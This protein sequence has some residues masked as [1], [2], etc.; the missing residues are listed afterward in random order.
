MKSMTGFGYHE[1]QD[2]KRHITITLKSY[3][4]RFLDI[5]VFLPPAL[6]QL[7]QRFREYLA[8]RIRRG[9]VELY[10]KCEEYESNPTVILDKA[11]VRAYAQALRE[12]AVEIGSNEPIRLSH[13]LKLEG[14]L[15]AEQSRD[16][17][18]YWGALYPHLETA[19]QDFERMRL[20]EGETTEQDIRRL[21][22]QIE[23]SLAVVESCASRIEEK[24]REDLRARFQEL[25][26]GGL[27][28]ARLMAETAVLLMRFDIHE[29]LMRIGNHLESFQAVMAEGGADGKKL[30]FLCQEL[31]REVNTVG[32]KSLFAE[33]NQ[34]VV[35]LKD[36]LEKIR[37]Q[38]RNVE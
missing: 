7:E 24:V 35:S 23:G 28:E 18:E 16:A 1:H 36:C 13:L 25:M 2:E 37:E 12:L 29:E 34:A 14:V 32:S 4:N 8:A 33:V 15:K 31:N 22:G 20:K 17:G 3:N 38:L 26:G 10:L 9:R 27:D 19:F 6:G 30:D 21:L 5:F 11:S